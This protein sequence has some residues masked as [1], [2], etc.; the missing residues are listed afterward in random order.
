MN[1]RKYLQ[2]IINKTKY[3]VSITFN[4]NYYLSERTCINMVSIDICIV[5]LLSKSAESLGL[6]LA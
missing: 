2:K 5:S 3:S 1:D 6:L 4:N